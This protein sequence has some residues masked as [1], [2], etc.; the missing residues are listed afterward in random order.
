[1]PFDPGPPIPPY[2]TFEEYKQDELGPLSKIDVVLRLDG[3]IASRVVLGS[4]YQGP[5]DKNEWSELERHYSD[6]FADFV[7]DRIKGLVETTP[8]ESRRTKFDTFRKAI[9]EINESLPIET[10]ESAATLPL[11]AE[12]LLLKEVR[13]QGLDP[14][15]LEV[16]HIGRGGPL[17]L[18][19]LFVTAAKHD[20]ERVLQ[21]DGGAVA[22]S[23]DR[24]G[25]ETTMGV[26]AHLVQELIEEAEQLARISDDEDEIRNRLAFPVMMVDL[27]KN[28]DEGLHAWLDAD[29][30]AILEMA[31]ATGKTVAGIAAIAYLCG[32]LPGWQGQSSET[33]D[34]N[35]MIVAHSNAILSQWRHEI[36][37][38]LGFS[39]SA[40]AG[41]GNTDPLHMTTGTIELHTAHWLQERYERDL[42]ECY[43]LIIYDEV[44]HLS[45]EEGLGEAI[46][47]PNYDAA[48]GL[49]ATIQED[50]GQQRRQRL[51]ELL[52][53]I[54]FQYPLTEAIDD[55]IIP[56]FEWTVHPTTLDPD[57]QQ[58][59]QEKTDTITALF[60][61]IQ[62]S[63][64]TRNILQELSVPFTE[65]EH[66]GDF[67]QAH[68]AA[69]Y[70]YDG[71]LPEEWTLLHEA[72]TSR[73]W[74]RHRSQPKIDRAVELAKE[75]LEQSDHMKIM[76]FAMDIDTT[77][78]IEYRLES[79]ADT[80]HAVHSQVAPSSSEK[81]RIVQQRI[82][83]FGRA[84]HGVLIAPKLLDEGI[85]VPDA[86]VGINVA[87]TK[88]K[89][90]LVQRM[91]RILRKHA[92]Q[93]PKFHHFVAV[94]DD[95]YIEGLDS[96]E[97]VQEVNWVRELGE[98]IEKQPEFD[99][100]AVDSTVIEKAKR[101]GHEQWARDLLEELDVETVQGS[102][103][104]E[105]IV[106]SLTAEA[107][108]EILTIVS[109]KHD[110]VKETD[111]QAAME[112]LREHSEELGLSVR[113]R[114]H[115]WW[116]FPVYRDQPSELKRILREIIGTSQSV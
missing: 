3:E 18:L 93:E 62:G 98:L 104:L 100:A 8:V 60:Q 88:T 22:E 21:A 103:D 37:E 91:G 5:V 94:P 73:T 84:D 108:A 57:D 19:E 11:P 106:N 61:T 81:N 28:Q 66:V 69:D 9:L 115:I 36:S 96:R 95:N 32:E 7:T 39:V 79:H 78:E 10:A 29:R 59:W 105:E 43:D 80:V 31:T 33:D 68:S 52:A 107:S 1:M 109:F 75:Y 74:I 92:D 30:E 70:G 34:A 83:E 41:G 15:R 54:E 47:R 111:W 25:D 2:W 101:R 51:E 97:Y 38:K 4:R 49:S 20:A 40:V 113:D 13:R 77:E 35:I 58:E 99:E 46:T 23:N 102:V 63:Q 16:E 90:Q 27:W 45:R 64:T 110:E 24:V 67:V 65:L 55:E 112:T 26:Q 53:P 12:Q 50:E 17:Y 72:I 14:E 71:E 76:M 116:L 44:H 114:Q 6:R 42:A 89:L 85:D 56:Q 87:G 48:L 82:N 86:E